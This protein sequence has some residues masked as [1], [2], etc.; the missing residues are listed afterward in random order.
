MNDKHYEMSELISIKTAAVMLGVSD[1]S[2]RNYIA[3]GKLPAYR[4]AGHLFRLD[5]ADVL[6]L[7]QPVEL[8]GA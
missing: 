6:E 5:A 3:A 7:L 8:G 1:R 2:I 4:V